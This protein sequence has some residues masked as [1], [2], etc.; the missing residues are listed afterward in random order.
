MAVVLFF[1]PILRVCPCEAVA[2]PAS[3]AG[4]QAK[5]VTTRLLETIASMGSDAAV[6]QLEQFCCF[7]AS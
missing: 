3:I 1:L 7:Q 6:L 2:C 4:S 5:A